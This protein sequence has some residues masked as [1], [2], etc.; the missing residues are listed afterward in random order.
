MRSLARG[1]LRLLGPLVSP[2]GSR[3]PVSSCARCRPPRPWRLLVPP[4]WPP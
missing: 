1:G 4:A 3:R 2:A